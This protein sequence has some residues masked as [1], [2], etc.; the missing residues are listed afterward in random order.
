MVGAMMMVATIQQMITLKLV[1]TVHCRA[2]RTAAGMN[3]SKVH[4]LKT[5]MIKQWPQPGLP[6]IYLEVDK[7]N[8][9]KLDLSFAI[10]GK[11]YSYIAIALG[12]TI[13]RYD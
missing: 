5:P 13:F 1:P 10:I 7:A 3:L 11:S 2:F 8:Q 9:Y 12:N 6:E 4:G